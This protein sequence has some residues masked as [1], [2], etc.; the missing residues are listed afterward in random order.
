MFKTTIKNIDLA[1]FDF[2]TPLFPDVH[3]RAFWDTKVDKTLIEKAESY[4]TYDWPIIKATDYMEYKKTGNRAIMEDIHFARRRALVTLSLSELME[5]KGR[6]LPQITN[7]IF[8]ICEESYWGVSA[9]WYCNVIGNIQSPEYPYIDL[10]AAQTAQILSFISV[11]LRKPLLDFCPEIIDRV[12]YEMERRIFVPYLTHHDYWWMGYYKKVNNWNPW[13]LSN[14]LSSFLLLEKNPLRMKKA[15]AKMLAEITFYYDCMP[16]DGGC[17]EGPGYWTRAGASLFEFLDQLKIA[18]GGKINLF[19]DEKIKKIGAYIAKVYIAEGTVM[20]FG[21]GGHHIGSAPMIY[22]YGKETEQP[23]MMALAAEITAIEKRKNLSSAHSEII[24]FRRALYE[25]STKDEIEAK[26][27]PF[28]P[29]NLCLFPDL[30][31]AALRKDGWIL[32]AKGGNNAEFHNHNDVGNFLLYD[33]GTPVLVDAGV[34]DYTRQTFGKERYTIWTMQ[35]GY[36]NLPTVNGIDQKDGWKFRADS[37]SAEESMATI[38]FKSAYPEESDLRNLTRTL[39]LTDEGFTMTDKFSFASGS[40]TIVEHM[41]TPYCPQVT[42]SSVLLD[43]KYEII[44]DGGTI[45][46]DEIHFAG[47]HKLE[48]SWKN[49]VLYRINVDYGSQETTTIRVRR[50]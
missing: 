26:S 9:H 22:L 17:D 49:A 23:E 4:L 16:N 29:N 47:N 45:S 15:I 35:S 14:V 19:G 42:D 33:N 38:S 34:G 46:V 28:S 31:V 27:I 39:L 25:L 13:I 36:H 32:G 44:C 50:I 6:F 12:D 7:G 20:N 8:T 41:L 18:T 1:S 43:G 5:N 37:F 2:S 30:Q 21:D 24:D 3:D 10:F 48:S 40:G 11:L